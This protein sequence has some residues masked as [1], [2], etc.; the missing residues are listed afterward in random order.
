MALTETVMRERPRL[1]LITPARIDDPDTFRATLMQCLT[2][3]DVACLQIR[4]KSG[5]EI[6]SDATR[7]IGLQLVGPVQGQGV[8]VVINDSV[9]LAEELGAD[10]VHLGP[11]DMGVKAARQ[12]LG[13]EA[14][15]GFSAKG[16]R[17]AAMQAGE[18]GADYVA[19]G[20]FYPTTTKTGATPA[21]PELLRLWQEQ[22]EIPCVA[23][24]GIT[25]ENADP[26][27][28]AGAD[29][30]AV[31]SGVWQAEDGPAAA[32]AGFN[33]LMDRYGSG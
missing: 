22:M 11:T 28:A 1:Y 30:L 10:G 7:A 2:V 4:L 15:I 24:G 26:L 31:S 17:H 12:R 25:R 13:A 32:V 6:D 9:E 16:S 21:D 27:L 19:F 23:I 5:D 14:I 18:A 20:A 8:A 3:G 33:R 29:F